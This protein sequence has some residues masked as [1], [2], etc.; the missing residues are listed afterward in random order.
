MK[1]MATVASACL[2]ILLAAAG[3]CA[4]GSGGGGGLAPAFGDAM[5]QVGDV[6]GQREVVDENLARADSAVRVADKATRLAPLGPREEH[7]LGRAVAANV[8]ARYG[9]YRDDAAT[10]YVNLL[11]Q[12]IA[13][14][15]SQ[16]ST[17]GGYRFIILDTDEVNAISAPGGFVMVTRGMLAR[18]G[19]EHAVAAVLA[20]EIAHVQERHGIEL[21]EGQRGRDFMMTVAGEAVEHFGDAEVAQLSQ[22]L[23]TFVDDYIVNLLDAGYERGLE[24]D[25]DRR[26][27]TLM[28][29][30]GYDPNGLRD[31]LDELRR[32]SSGGAGWFRTHPA[33]GDRLSRLGPGVQR[34]AGSDVR[35]GRFHAAMA[36]VRGR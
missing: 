30:A 24:F 23:S 9:V 4:E 31:V 6:F 5:R 36:A 20:H 13:L 15:S 34:A 19:S 25:S 10:R 3:G 14:S 12:S 2:G 1:S 16:P 7:Y 18:C 21:V 11:G 22:T 29:D 17:W 33:P 26:A 27:V 8:I 35:D 32:S 28:R